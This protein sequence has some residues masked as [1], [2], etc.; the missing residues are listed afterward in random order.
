M[1]AHKNISSTSNDK[2]KHTNT[3]LYFKNYCNNQNQC[4]A[5]NKQSSL[6]FDVACCVYL[7][8]PNIKTQLFIIFVHI[9]CSSAINSKQC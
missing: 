1:W 8:I 7:N 4:N 3:Y 9:I 5:I 2:E 6:D